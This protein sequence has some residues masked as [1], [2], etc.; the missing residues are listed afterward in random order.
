MKIAEADHG[1]AHGD[2]LTEIGGIILH[3]VSDSEPLITLPTFFGID[4]SITKHVVMLWVT[5]VVVFSI[6]YFATKRYRQEEYPVPTGFTNAFES[7]VD[8][9]R[10][11]VVRPN[12]GAEFARVWAPLILTFFFFILTANSLGLIPIFDIMPGGSTATGNF[13]VTAGLATVTFFGIIAAGSLK[14]GFLGHWKNLAPPG[15]PFLIY[16]ILV[17]IEII[18][19]FVKPFALTMRLA[20]N[21]TGGH[22]AILSIMSFIFV[23]GEMFS[24]SAGIA[25]GVFVSVPLNVA[26]SGL[27]IIVILI[28]AYVFTLLS[29]IFIGMAIHPHH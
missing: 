22:I 19:I 28:Q 15:Q 21:M 8:F 2:I 29:A 14:H 1:E 20:A 25:V 5:A 11:Q 26:I 3:H 17:P 9:I 23:F 27:E 12:V 24:P 16:F 13:N 7:V 10:N 18:A 4:F 6:S